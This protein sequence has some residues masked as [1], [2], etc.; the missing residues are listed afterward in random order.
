VDVE[1]NLQELNELDRFHTT[2]ALQ[3]PSLS[4][5]LSTIHTELGKDVLHLHQRHEHFAEQFAEV[6]AKRQLLEDLLSLITKLNK[7]GEQK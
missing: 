6:M 2:V 7:T 5:Y 1:R 4:T 3:T